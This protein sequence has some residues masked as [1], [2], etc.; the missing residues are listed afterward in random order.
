MCIHTYVLC[1]VV[2]VNYRS[3]VCLKVEQFKGWIVFGNDKI[4]M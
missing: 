2:T 3:F 4:S 1:D